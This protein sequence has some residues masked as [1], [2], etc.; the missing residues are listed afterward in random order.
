MCHKITFSGTK[1]WGKARGVVRKVRDEVDAVHKDK[2]L[3][4]REN[5]KSLS[6]EDR[7]AAAKSVKEGDVRTRFGATLL[8]R[9]N[10]WNR[11][12]TQEDYDKKRITLN[13]SYDARKPDEQD[14]VGSGIGGY[15]Q[16]RNFR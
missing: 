15:E 5:D 11:K 13:D 8:R 3:Y 16:K 1:G 4:T 12:L 2:S 10:D 9:S 14:E 7:M 6:P